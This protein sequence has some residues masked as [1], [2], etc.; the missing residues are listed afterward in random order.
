[1]LDSSLEK[2]ITYWLSTIT[3]AKHA[4]PDE[5]PDKVP[6][7]DPRPRKRQRVACDA[8]EGPK[9]KSQILSTRTDAVGT[10]SITQFLPSPDSSPA[11]TA[12]PNY[13]A[14]PDMERPPRT[15]SPHKRLYGAAD[16][17]QPTVALEEETPR[18]VAVAM[19]SFDLSS[20]L[21]FET[22]SSATHST[23]SAASRSSSP[24]K[25]LRNAEILWSGFT[26]DKFLSSTPR[27]QSLVALHDELNSIRLGLRVIPCQF[28]S[29][30]SSIPPHAFFDPA[31]DPTTVTDWRIP[32]LNWVSRTVEEATRCELSRDAES[33][34]NHAVHAR[35]LNWVCAP[36]DAPRGLVAVK[37]CTTAQILKEFRPKGAPTHMV[38][39]CLVIDPTREVAACQRIN[40]ICRS[41][42][43]AS[44]NH[45]D[46]GS[47]ATHPIA[48]SIE[49]KRPGEEWSKAMLQLGTWHAAQLRS[50]ENLG[51]CPTT[52][53][54]EFLP[55]LIV[56][57]H[58]WYFVAT[59]PRS[60]APPTVF[61]RVRIGSTE[62]HFGVYQ[63]VLALQHVSRW[64]EQVF[65]PAMRSEILDC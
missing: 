36:E 54:M 25:R 63:L 49:T 59:V 52:S 42:P 4:D 8:S 46:M 41:R 34:W 64:A 12:T 23:A 27:P 13:R 19:D 6:D 17:P 29:A 60:D 21:S 47:L 44:I 56:Q 32:S 18:A 58:D 53:A 51:H 15:P 7:S 50:L 38:D 39:Y 65:W 5:V 61:T 43:G 11:P 55:A 62:D 30:G 45:T 24:N 40:T 37:H 14:L 9:A 1:M 33:D 3:A 57:G 20:Q 48:V 10:D 31:A 2:A 28:Q 22:A 26:T 35:V 16:G